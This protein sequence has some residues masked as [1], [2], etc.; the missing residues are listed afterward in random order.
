MYFSNAAKNRAG[1]NLKEFARDADNIIRND[2]VVFINTGFNTLHFFLHRHQAGRPIQTQ[3]NGAKW[4]IMPLQVDIPAELIS[5][6]VPKMQA[7]L[8]TLGVYRIENVRSRLAQMIG[9]EET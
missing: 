4:A 8:F 6:P 5:K 3:I 2:P 1:D 9:V 7:R